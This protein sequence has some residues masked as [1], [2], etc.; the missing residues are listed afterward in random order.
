MPSKATLPPINPTLAAWEQ[1][2]ELTEHLP[3]AVKEA[4]ARQGGILQFEKR[5]AE[6]REYTQSI[7]PWDA[8]RAGNWDFVYGGIVALLE[9]Y[10]SMRMHDDVWSQQRAYWATCDIAELLLNFHLISG[11]YEDVGEVISRHIKHPDST[12]E[13]VLSAGDREASPERDERDDLGWEIIGDPDAALVDEI[14][15]AGQFKVASKDADGNADICKVMGRMTSFN[16]RDRNYNTTFTVEK[17]T[18]T[19]SLTK[20]QLFA[21][22]RGRFTHEAAHL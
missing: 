12:I 8:R 4:L 17:G 11:R 6:W 3:R 10:H 16:E 7:Y 2:Q 18:D 20:D 14:F 1:W 15:R 9:E 21:L 19:V 13:E 22:Y 5:R